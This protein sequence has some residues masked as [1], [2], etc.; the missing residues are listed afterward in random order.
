MKAQL[1][2][3]LKLAIVLSLST[4]LL[5]FVWLEIGPEGKA[6]YGE[7]V[8]DI[9]ILG[10]YI[11]GKDTNWWAIN[12][13][14]KLQL[15]FILATSLNSYLTYRFQ[16][17]R[18]VVISLLIINLFFLTI[19]PFWLKIYVEGVINNSD[20]AANDLEIHYSVGLIVWL[21]LYVIN[22]LVLKITLQNKQII[23]KS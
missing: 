15:F 11:L 23:Q 1:N 14:Y 17:K 4:L 3:L 18:K 5:P 7:N 20:G 13:A 21:V 9:Y 22:V 8:P 6:Y 12:F 19:F 2:N 10:A 16:D